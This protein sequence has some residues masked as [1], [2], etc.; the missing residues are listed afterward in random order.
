MIR[1]LPPK[2]IK[3]FFQDGTNDLD[4]PWGNWFLANEEM[5]SAIN[6]SNRQADRVDEGNVRW[7]PY[8]NSPTPYV[9]GTRWQEK[10]VWTDGEHSDQHG[11][12]LL[13]DAIRW[14]WSEE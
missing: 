1:R 6:F 13:P 11:G 12:H 4:N 8:R 9:K 7:D 14:L 5:V 2:P 3:I 10:H